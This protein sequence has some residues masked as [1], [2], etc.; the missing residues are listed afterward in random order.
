M[1]DDLRDLLNNLE[2]ESDLG[3]VLCSHGSSFSRVHLEECNV[4]LTELKPS[5][6]AGIEDIRQVKRAQEKKLIDEHEDRDLFSPIVMDG[7]SFEI[8]DHLHVLDIRKNLPRNYEVFLYSSFVPD[9]PPNPY[10]HRHLAI[11]VNRISDD[12]FLKFR[13]TSAINC[14][15]NNLVIRAKVCEWAIHFDARVIGATLDAL[16][17]Q[18]RKFDSEA[19]K[20]KLIEDI[21]QFC[22]D[23]ESMSSSCREDLVEKLNTHGCV[24]FWWD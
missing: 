4:L 15:L 19:W 14:K 18:F 17:V 2:F 16:Y 23:K 6:N 8:D 5:W 24:D 3:D 20:P 10:C 21:I 9:P 7:V 1:S 11:L 13:R 12:K 22:P